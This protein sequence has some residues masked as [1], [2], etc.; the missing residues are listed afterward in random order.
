MATIR[1]RLHEAP[2]NRLRFGMIVLRHHGGIDPRRIQRLGR[3]RRNDTT[4]RRRRPQ[5]A[6][7]AHAH[8]PGLQGGQESAIALRRDRPH[9]RDR[10]A[11]EGRRHVRRRQRT[12][13]RLQE[14][15]ALACHLAQRERGHDR[16]GRDVQ[17]QPRRVSQ[18][19][20]QQLVRRA[21][22]TIAAGTPRRA[23]A[24]PQ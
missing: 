5:P 10:R 8:E 6:L 9:E 23:A 17:V 16:A 1:S 12:G 4:V 20:Q 21:T 7:Q 11:T 18:R 19:L 22:V 2:G 15:R 14:Q 13:P 24:S 3:Q